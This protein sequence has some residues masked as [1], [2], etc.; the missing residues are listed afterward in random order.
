MLFELGEEVSCV[1]VAQ[2][3][4][5]LCNGFVIDDA[6]A[7]QANRINELGMKTLW[8]KND[9]PWA[10]EFSNE[11]FI[12]YRTENLTNFLKEFNELRKN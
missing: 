6:D 3:L 5:S 4:I 2:R 12:N 1:G 9:E 7:S 10:A 8:I 11:N